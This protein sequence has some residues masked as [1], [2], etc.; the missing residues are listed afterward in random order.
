MNPRP[1]TKIIL[2][3]LFLI[4]THPV[5]AQISISAE[6][7]LGQTGDTFQELLADRDTGTLPGSLGVLESLLTVDGINSSFDFT[8]IT[9]ELPLFS[10]NQYLSLPSDSVDIPGYTTFFEGLATDAW[11][12]QL[13]DEAA[14]DVFIFRKITTDSLAWLGNGVWQDTNNDGIADPVVSVFT[15]A[16]LQAPLPLELNDAWTMDFTHMSVVDTPIGTVQVPGIREEHD[17]KVDGYGMLV[18]HLGEYPCLRVRINQ[19]IHTPGGSTQEIGGWSFIT[20]ELVQ[21]GIFYDQLIP[22]DLSQ[23]TFSLQEPQ[24]IS[25]F[26]PAE[27]GM[28]T[29]SEVFDPAPIRFQLSNNYPNPFQTSTTIPVEL[30]EAG[31]VRLRIFNA[32]GQL[33]A[34]PANGYYSAGS[35]RFEWHATGAPAGIYFYQLENNGNIDQQ[36][37]TLIR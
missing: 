10:L 22:D 12:V 24:S 31:N 30:K 1:T 26:T 6:E 33:M 16:K 23:A 29:A 32:L 5:K 17:I 21:L 11:R 34:T 13:I 35:H 19:T 15:P 14:P 28:S 18:T 20:S 8:E 25:L 3:L 2:A 9:A 27:E 36:Q 7:F 37:M 4:F